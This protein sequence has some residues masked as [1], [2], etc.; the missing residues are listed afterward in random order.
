MDRY[1]LLGQEDTTHLSNVVALFGLSELLDLVWLYH[2]K[3]SYGTLSGLLVIA[4]RDVQRFIQLL[5]TS[6][7]RA[8]LPRLSLS[9]QPKLSL[10]TAGK[11]HSL[12]SATAIPRPCRSS[13]VSCM[14]G[15]MLH[16]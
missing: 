15:L 5:L 8:L 11:V 14:N 6:Y 12:D 3:G 13:A 16:I 10:P 4:V 1:G 9:L 2:W 7:A